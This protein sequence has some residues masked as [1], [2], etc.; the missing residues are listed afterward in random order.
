MN[1]IGSSDLLM[2]DPSLINLIHPDEWHQSLRYECPNLKIYASP[3]YIKKTGEIKTISDLYGL[4]F[5]SR[6]TEGTE[7]GILRLFNET[8]NE[9]I[10]CM[11]NTVSVVEYDKIKLD[12][13]KQGIG[14]GLLKSDGIM[15]KET[16]EGLV[17]V[18]PEYSSKINLDLL[19]LTK[20]NNPEITRH[21]INQIREIRSP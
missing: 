21:I 16:L 15:I 8:N 3:Q 6:K 4:N 2:L 7:H 10:N 14:I 12:Q 1:I 13:I 18:L 19:I 5:I 9:S 17:E 20:K 11:V